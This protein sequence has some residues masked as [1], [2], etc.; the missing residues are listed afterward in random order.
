MRDLV[1]DNN[2]LILVIGGVLV[3]RWGLVTNL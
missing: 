3:Y 1:K 2:V